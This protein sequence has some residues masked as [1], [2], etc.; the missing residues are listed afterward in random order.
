MVFGERN[1]KGMLSFVKIWNKALSEKEIQKP[2]SV[3]QDKN[4]VFYCLFDGIKSTK[5]IVTGSEFQFVK[6]KSFSGEKKKRGLKRAIER[7]EHEDEDE[8]V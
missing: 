8:D 6:A 7:E 4:L 2:T 5:E 1:L 3:V